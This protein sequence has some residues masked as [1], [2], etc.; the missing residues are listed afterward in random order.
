[1]L[2][3][4]GGVV[5]EVETDTETRE[6]GGDGQQEPVAD[7]RQPGPRGDGSILEAFA[8]GRV[9]LQRAAVPYGAERTVR[10]DRAVRAS[11]L[12]GGGGSGNV[13]KA[14]QGGFG[15]GEPPMEVIDEVV[16]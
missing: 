11:G 7:S 13:G 8:P 6:G 3:R 10:L 12:C 4:L 9:R 5:R 15:H 14:E 16:L 1:G 2:A